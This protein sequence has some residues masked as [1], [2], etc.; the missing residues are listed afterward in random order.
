MGRHSAP[1]AADVIAAA[2]LTNPPPTGRHRHA[3]PKP[4]WRRA[5]V[6][7]TAAVVLTLFVGSDAL[8]LSGGVGHADALNKGAADVEGGTDLSALASG[9][10][11]SQLIASGQ[12]VSR[13]SRT[14]VLAGGSVYTYQ[15]RPGLPA[16]NPDKTVP[17]VWVRPSA[18]PETSCFCMRWGVMHEG[19]DL[20]GPMAHRSSR[21]ATAWW[22]RPDRPRAS[23]CGW[24]SGTTTAT[25]RSTATCTTTT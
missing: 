21:S 20:A 4:A 22:W 6:V 13:S 24:S 15:A 14:S 11:A 19:I 7:P 1:R 2:A 9:S 16:L 10:A 18:G 23:G 3:A 17:G 12:R 5:H 8:H 25:S